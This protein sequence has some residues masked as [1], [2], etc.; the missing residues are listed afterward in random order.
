[1]LQW[2]RKRI[3]YVKNLKTSRSQIQE[4]FARTEQGGKGG[5]R[6]LISH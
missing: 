2:G 3:Q 1:M 6:G 4:G 5:V